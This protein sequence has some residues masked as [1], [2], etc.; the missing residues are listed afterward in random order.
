MDRDEPAGKG[1]LQRMTTLRFAN[2]TFLQS[3]GTVGDQTACLIRSQAY[4]SMYIRKYTHEALHI[5]MFIIVLNI[6]L[7]TVLH[8]H[9][10]TFYHCFKVEDVHVCLVGNKVSL[11]NLDLASS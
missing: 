9:T 8:C 1:V 7:S 11:K 10:H 2:L 6:S 5:Y 4:L 3:N